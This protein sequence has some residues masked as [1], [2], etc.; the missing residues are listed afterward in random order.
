MLTSLSLNLTDRFRKHAKTPNQMFVEFAHEKSVMFD[1]WCSASNIIT[2]EQLKELMLLEEFKN[3]VPKKIVVYLNERNVSSLSEA[4]VMADEFVLT[5]K[6]VFSPPG[7]D[8]ITGASVQSSVEVNKPSAVLSDTRECFYC[9]EVGHLIAVCPALERKRKKSQTAIRSVGIIKAINL[10]ENEMLS[11]PVDCAFEPF[12][13]SGTV[14]LS[15]MD[16]VRKPIRILRDTGATQSMLLGSVLPLSVRSSCGNNVLVQGVGGNVTTAPLHNIHLESDLF[17]GNV[18]V[19]IC[20]KLP[21]KG[22]YLILGNDVAGGKVFPLPTIK[23]KLKT[24]PEN[25]VQKSSV[26]S[27]RVVTRAQA[28]KFH[29]LL[30]D[31]SLYN[32][33]KSDKL[34]RDH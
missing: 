7:G 29:V 25:P 9:H 23:N 10:E 21:F 18:K 5:H 27:V 1:K 28:R 30:E 12:T 6:V 24:N 15:E 16:S 19:G 22:I 20:S 13:S 32:D 14:T 8:V 34:S 11:S 3:C 33:V 17:S 4:A 2:F 26:C 31:D